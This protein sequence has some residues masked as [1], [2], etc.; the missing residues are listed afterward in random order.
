[1]YSILYNMVT[2]E[3]FKYVL[4]LWN[5][6]EIPSLIERN[7]NIDLDANKVIAI[8]GVRRSGKTHVMFQ[9]INALLKRGV[10]N[11]NIFYVDFENER[12]I[13]LQA[14]DL[15]RLLIAHRELFNP[16]GTIYIFLDEI[17]NVENWEK[18]V[19]KIYDTM[20]YRIIISGSSSKLLSREIATSLAGRNLTYVVYPFS[21]EEYVSAKKLRISNLDKYSIDKGIILK[22]IDE[23]LE[24]G[25]FPEIALASSVS[26]KLEVLSSYFDAI[27][28]RDILRRYRIR[29]VGEL[30]VFL[31]IISSNYSSYFSSVKS[32]NYFSS[33]GM[34]ISRITILNFLE[35]TKSVFL[36]G[37]L[38]QYEKS[39][40]KRISRKPKTYIIDVGIS[41]LFSDIDKGRALENA[42]YLELLRR[43]GPSD[44]INF[45]KLKSGKE[46]DFIFGGRTKELIQVSYDVSVTITRSR[47][48]G[49][50]VEA[51]IS[52]GL[53][54][55]T[56]ITYDYEGTET[57]GGILIKYTPFWVWATPG[58]H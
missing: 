49:A 33:L 42:V 29:E 7:V 17:Q 11:D 1:M 14:T 53:K 46:V 9:C 18:W 32:L 10:R 22:A 25:S 6:Y 12:L 24:Y 45:L 57:V 36:V 23:F 54:H 27:F 34:K 26:R 52:L 51:A 37:S 2:I 3:D 35:Y 47:E 4:T 38:E 19:R 58:I 16:E 13:G 50:I 43:K 41:R 55:G 5:N 8:A 44:T 15:D 40:R 21:F 30:N 56:I 28:F 20:K 48:T 39:V 31:K